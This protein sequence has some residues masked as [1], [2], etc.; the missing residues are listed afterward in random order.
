[1][2]RFDCRAGARIRLCIAGLALAVLTIGAHAAPRTPM[3]AGV[4]YNAM[5]LDIIAGLASGGGYSRTASQVALPT[6]T[7]HNIGG[8]RW[9]MRVYDGHP[10]YCTSAT[11][12]VFAH[13]V[14]V[15]H[16]AGSIK[17]APVQLRALSIMR[18]MPGGRARQ[19]GEGP[20]AIFNANGA[21]VAALLKHTG[22]GFSFRDDSLAYARPGDFLKIFW[23]NNVGATESGHQVVYTGRRQVSGRDMVCFW[24][25]QRQGK[26]KR[27]GRKEALYFPAAEGGEVKD[28]YGEVCRPRSDIK[29]MI[30]SRVTCMEHLAAGLANMGAK[31]AARG[32]LPDLFVDEYLRTISSQSSDQATLDRMYDIK[33]APDAAFAD[34]GIAER[35]LAMSP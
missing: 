11:Y 29:E 18:T 21:G 20:F 1:M 33:T 9:E 22:T 3:C 27:E 8:G 23:N 16:N 26:K 10:S 12:S 2:T 15:L 25:S 32:G 28:G 5:I 4:D 17:L 6:V 31:A 35:P 30:F 14:A 24:S 19:D 13:L 34:V 7:S